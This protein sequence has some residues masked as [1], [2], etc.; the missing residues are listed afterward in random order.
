[1]Y[2]Y[3]CP[4]RKGIFKVSMIQLSLNDVAC[5]GCIGKIKRKIKRYNGIEKVRILAG[6]GKIEIDY[7][8]A[9]IETEEL[10]STI[11]KLVIRTFD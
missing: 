7:N 9:I 2:C 10:N 3:N 11:H 4:Y 8:E 6:S 1:M 5:S